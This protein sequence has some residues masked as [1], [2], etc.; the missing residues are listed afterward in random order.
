MRC[1]LPIDWLDWLE[2]G[3]PDD[4]TSHL[5]D[6]PSC[7]SLVARM[8]E[9]SGERVGEWFAN[10]SLEQAT[11]WQPHPIEA[12]TLGR[13]VLNAPDYASE[14]I[15]YEDLERLLFL[16]LDEGREDYGRRW[17]SVAPADTD[18]ENASST[19]LLLE[20]EETSL[21]VP[22][23][24]LFSLQTKLVREQ[25]DEE[26]GALTEEGIQIIER[27]FSRELDELRFGLPL[28]GPDDERLAVDH[29]TEAIVRLLRTPFFAATDDVATEES[30]ELGEEAAHSGNLFYFHFTSMHEAR[31][32]FSLAAQ[33]MPKDIEKYAILESHFGRMAGRLRYEFPHILVF[34]IDQVEGFTSI[35]VKLIVETTSSKHFESPPFTPHV[36]EE[37]EVAPVFVQEVDKLAIKVGQ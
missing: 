22:L 1:P 24:I 17:F 14:E 12:L 19:D 9:A 2:T 29:D 36:G 3:I 13:L 28:S 8:R 6:C 35:E 27:A 23:R 5:E 33:T 15:D 32:S 30:E 26:V 25:L 4:P 31:E 16:V 37:I 7:Q 34:G 10:V 18:I 21:G 11:V 20:A